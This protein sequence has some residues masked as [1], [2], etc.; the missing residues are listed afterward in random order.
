MRRFL[1]ASPRSGSGLRLR[2]DGNDGR[3]QPHQT[4]S[5]VLRLAKAGAL[6]L[7]PA[8]SRFCPSSCPPGLPREGGQFRVGEVVTSARLE[9]QGC[10]SWRPHEAAHDGSCRRLR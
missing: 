3:V 6:S 2:F 8:F 7:C 4:G 10:C 9:D 5:R 1:L